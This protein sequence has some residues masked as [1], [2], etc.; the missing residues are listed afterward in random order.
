MEIKLSDH[1]TF[2]K[3]FRFTLPTIGMMLFAS[4]Y[5]IVDGLFVSNLVGKTPF[6]ALNLIFPFIQMLTSVG[7][8]VGTGGTAIVSMLLGQKD[9]KKAN[10]VFS[11][12]VYFTI[13]IGFTLSAI[14]L[15]SLRKVAALL[16]ASPE[17]MRDCLVYGSILLAAL[18]AGLLQFAF[19]PFMIA[20]EKPNMGF[21]VTLS[22]GLTNMVLDALFIWGF[23]WGLA[24][25]A[26]ATAMSQCVAGCV[27]L[28]YFSRKNSSLLRLGKAV[29]D[30]RVIIHS[31]ANGS[32]ELLSQVSMSVVSM[33]YNFQLM[34]YMGEDGVSALGIVLYINFIFLALF[35][36]YSV[37]LE[38]VIG[39][40]YGSKN[41]GE[42]KN[43]FKKSLF[44]I[45][46]G[47]VA[48]TLSAEALAGPLASLFVG[49]DTGLTEITKHAFR[50]YSVSFLLCGFNIFGSALFTALSNGVISACVSFFRT[51]V[52]EVSAILLLPL[53]FGIDGIWGAVIAAET[54]ALSLTVFFVLRFRNR[55]HYF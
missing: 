41:H 15:L 6:A 36:G 24:G 16:G 18:P 30:S 37:G 2:G 55:Y 25:A 54:V 4:V 11:L 33:L 51:M 1:F 14:G 29:K 31:C 45:S 50:I 22:A 27:P 3:L 19:Q 20:A 26:V 49:Y 46:I 5:S 34:K 9:N 8:M 38:P 13:I 47:A 32:S 44:V 43:I 48:M 10:E 53:V 28:V 52:C 39:Y 42:L 35:I 21:F 12:L 7:F 23:G 40:N 17:M